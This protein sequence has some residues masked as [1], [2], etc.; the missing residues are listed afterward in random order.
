MV[1][2]CLTGAT[3]TSYDIPSIN[4]S[5]FNKLVALLER[6]PI[7]H[8]CGRRPQR[9]VGYQ[10]A[11]FLMRYGCRGADSLGVAQRMGIS[12]GSVFLYCRRVTRALRELGLEVV[13]WGDTERQAVVKDYIYRKTGLPDCL[14]FLD[15]TLIKLTH[16]P[17]NSGAVFYS[18][19]K[20]P[21]VS[22]QSP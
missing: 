9:P 13:T 12:F 19:K 14:G 11:C 4:R 15:G 16:A 2:I 3:L 18:R 20:F 8:S 21:A 1:S 22:Y 10:L 6:N 5:T 17:E 7:F